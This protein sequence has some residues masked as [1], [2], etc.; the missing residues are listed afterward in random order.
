[1]DASVT[2]HSSTG[3]LRA[4]KLHGD[5]SLEG[6]AALVDVRDISEA[7]VHVKTLNGA[8]TLSNVHDGHVEID[9]LSG[10]VTL[11]SVTG[12]LVQV[13]STSG[14]I[15]YVGDFGSSGEY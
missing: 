7:H 2:L 10:E 13:V 11:N 1:A 4:E 8:V 6:G 3:P 15:I 9:S 5:L 12:P 14:K